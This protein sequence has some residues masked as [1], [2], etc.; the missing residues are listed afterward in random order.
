MTF[1]ELLADLAASPQ[2]EVTIPTGWAQGRAGYGG[3]IAALVYQGMRA[4]VPAN[5]PVRSLAITFVGPVAPG[6]SMQVEAQ[7]LR[8]G[9]QPKAP[10]TVQKCPILK[11]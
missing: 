9:L 6:Q 3:L 8:E 10:L 4:K 11:G 7:V 5:R 2:Q 1:A